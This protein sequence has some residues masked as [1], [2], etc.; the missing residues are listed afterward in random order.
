MGWRAGEVEWYMS[1]AALGSAAHIVL[2]DVMRL[3]ASLALGEEC[4]LVVVGL[5]QRSSAETWC[6]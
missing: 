5:V 4:L 1:V 2:W 6:G 3:F